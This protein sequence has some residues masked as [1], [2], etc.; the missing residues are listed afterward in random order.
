MSDTIQFINFPNIGYISKKF[1]DT[2]LQPIRD[3]IQLIQQSFKNA[4]PFNSELAGHI[5]KEFQLSSNTNDYISRL[6]I[7]CATE[8]DIYYN[9]FSKINVLTKDAPMVLESSWVNFQEKYEFNPNHIHVGILSFVIWMSIPYNQKIESERGP[10]NM[11]TVNQS[12]NFQFTYTDIL[13]STASMSIPADNSFENTMVMF[14]A[15]LMHCVYPFY[16][17]NEYRISVSGNFK[18]RN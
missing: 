6:L 14:P 12:G 7:P 15:K 18:L 2:E 3:E 11:A 5:Q 10:G 1:T 16:T 9:F 17:S 4:K 8:Y 13:G